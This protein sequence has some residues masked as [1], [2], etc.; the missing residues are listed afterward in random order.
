MSTISTPPP[1]DLDPF[2]VG[3]RYVTICHPDGTE[4]VDQ[5][6]LTDVSGQ[7]ALPPF[8]GHE[9]LP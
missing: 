6:P 1:D 7:Q 2:C 4:S 3:W 8:C 9:V 5:V